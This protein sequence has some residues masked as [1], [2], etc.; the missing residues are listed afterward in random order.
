M[1]LSELGIIQSIIPLSASLRESDIALELRSIAS[2]SGELDSR[3]Y[4]VISLVSL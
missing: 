3:N 1:T 2:L 4:V